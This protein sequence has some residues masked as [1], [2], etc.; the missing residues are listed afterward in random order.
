MTATDLWIHDLNTS[1][2]LNSGNNFSQIESVM[3][4]NEKEIINNY[5]IIVE[6]LLVRNNEV[7][8]TKFKISK[9]FI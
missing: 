1:R 2:G 5:V 4:P 7:N 9:N 8:E 6:L 3:Y